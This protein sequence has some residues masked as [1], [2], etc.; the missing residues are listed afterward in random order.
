MSISRK[1]GIAAAVAAAV[2]VAGLSAFAGPNDAGKSPT[3][4]VKMIDKHHVTLSKA[5]DAAEKQ[6]KGRAIEGR[7]DLKNGELTFDILCVSGDKTSHV[8]IDGRT[9][10][11]Q[12]DSDRTAARPADKSLFGRRT[13]APKK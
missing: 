7:A 5:V 13:S 12:A 8:W 3:D 9:G 6:S 11:V 2:A 1:G 10:K 4:L